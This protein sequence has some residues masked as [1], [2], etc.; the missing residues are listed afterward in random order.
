MVR[1]EN[2]A[3]S[4]W[5]DARWLVIAPHPDDETLGAGALIATQAAAGRLSAVVF[6][7]DGAASHT[8]PDATSRERLTALRRD[9]AGAALSELCD[10]RPP[11]VIFLDWPDAQT[12]AVDEA[13]AQRDAKRLADLCDESGVTAVAVTARHEPHCDHAAAARLARA[14]VALGAQSPDLFEYLVWATTPPP[15]AKRAIRTDPVAPSLR[16]SAL[17]HHRSQLTDLMGPGFRLDPARRD[18]PATDILYLWEG[19]DAT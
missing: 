18:M 7:T 2:L 19:T 12:D 11:E 14:A 13:V 9:E 15:G 8:H 16:A 10:S 4:P 3:D 6:L 5:A 1:T 17:D